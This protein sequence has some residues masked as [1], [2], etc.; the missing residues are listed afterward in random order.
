MDPTD[1]RFEAI[2]I[3][4][5]VRSGED[6]K[7]NVDLNHVLARNGAL[8]D[9]RETHLKDISSTLTFSPDSHS[10]S[11]ATHFHRSH[12]NLVCNLIGVTTTL[13]PRRFRRYKAIFIIK[14]RHA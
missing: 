6:R 7:V 10:S 8:D 2:Y 13:P 14:T 9:V 4:N 12:T 11:I 3:A 5:I 1:A